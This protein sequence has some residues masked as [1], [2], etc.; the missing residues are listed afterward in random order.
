MMFLVGRPRQLLD[1]ALEVRD[2]LLVFDF[3][4]PIGSGWEEYEVEPPP[5][6]Q[7]GNFSSILCH[8]SAVDNTVNLHVCAHHVGGC[9]GSLAGLRSVFLAGI[10]VPAQRSSL[11]PAARSTIAIVVAHA[12]QSATVPPALLSYLD[13]EISHA[14]PM[15]T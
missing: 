15:T 11:R 13:G 9:S 3:S 7:L 4:V 10:A 1:T 6:A 2:V 14:R 8:C 12:D 5:R